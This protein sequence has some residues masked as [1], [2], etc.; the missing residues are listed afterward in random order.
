MVSRCWSSSPPSPRSPTG[1][2]GLSPATCRAI[3]STR[4]GPSGQPAMGT[5]KV[6]AY[7]SLTFPVIAG[8]CNDAPS[9]NTLSVARLIWRRLLTLAE[10]PSVA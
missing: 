1:G 4:S 7:P 8:I 9:L 10:Y 6:A 3:S 5:V 2:S